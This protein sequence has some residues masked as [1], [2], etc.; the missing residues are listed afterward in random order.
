MS[1]VTLV[2]VYA[3]TLV[4]TPP[5]TLSNAS[6]TG[7]VSIAL[8]LPSN[9]FT[10]TVSFSPW[11]PT[12]AA[13][14]WLMYVLVLASSNKALTRSHFSQRQIQ[15]EVPQKP[16]SHYLAWSLLSVDYTPSL[17]YQKWLV[18]GLA[19]RGSTIGFHLHWHTVELAM[20]T[21]LC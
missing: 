6:F 16:P 3:V 20:S 19:R 17:P 4:L 14:S 18:F 8:T 11:R 15:C 5:F 1:P 7:N 21:R 12:F 2:V 9:T 10:F 13:K